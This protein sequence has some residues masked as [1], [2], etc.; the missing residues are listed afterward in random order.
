MLER[1]DRELLNK[2]TNGQSAH[3]A[4]VISSAI[5]YLGALSEKYENKKYENKKLYGLFLEGKYPEFFKEAYD[6]LLGMDVLPSPGSELEAS[7]EATEILEKFR[8]RR[9]D[10]REVDWDVYHHMR[11]YSAAK[12]ILALKDS[13]DEKALYDT[14]VKELLKIVCG[15]IKEG[16]RV[17]RLGL[18]VAFGI[19]EDFWRGRFQ[20]FVKRNFSNDDYLLSKEFTPDKIAVLV[21]LRFL[22]L[23]EKDPEK[24]KDF[25]VPFVQ[26]MIA[27][28]TF[29]ANYEKGYVPSKCATGTSNEFVMSLQ[30]VDPE[31]EIIIDENAYV[32]SKIRERLEQGLDEYLLRDGANEVALWDTWGELER[33]DIATEFA[34]MLTVVF[35]EEAC[36]AI[37]DDCEIHG[38]SLRDFL[39]H[40]NLATLEIPG[41]YQLDSFLVLASKRPAYRRVFEIIKTLQSSLISLDISDKNK[42]SYDRLDDI[43]SYFQEYDKRRD[44]SRLFDQEYIFLDLLGDELR[45]I[46][47]FLSGDNSTL[48]NISPEFRDFMKAVSFEH[49]NIFALLSELE[50]PEDT[51]VTRVIEQLSTEDARKIISENVKRI[52]SGLTIQAGEI[53]IVGEFELILPGEI[54]LNA[55]D[56]STLL[57]YAILVPKNEWYQP[58]N[59][60]GLS[61]DNLLKI[62]LEFFEKQDAGNELEREFKQ[63][64]PL[65]IVLYIKY[66]CD[67]TKISERISALASTPYFS[68]G[69]LWQR[70][71]LDPL[72]FREEP[73]DPDEALYKNKALDL[74]ILLYRNGDFIKLLKLD[75]EG[76]LFEEQVLPLIAKFNESMGDSTEEFCEVWGKM[77]EANVLDDITRKILWENP[78]S[79]REVYKVFS[80]LKNTDGIFDV[81]TWPEFLGA[82]VEDVDLNGLEGIAT[83]LRKVWIMFNVAME[84]KQE[85]I[86]NVTRIVAESQRSDDDEESLFDFILTFSRSVGIKD[87]EHLKYAFAVYSLLEYAGISST[88]NMQKVFVHADGMAD[89][90]ALLGELSD[91]DE[92]YL[93]QQT[94][95]LIIKY[96]SKLSVNI[97][98]YVN[99]QT[100]GEIDWPDVNSKAAAIFAIREYNEYLT[101][102]DA[103]IFL[104]PRGI[105]CLN[106]A[107]AYN[108]NFKFIKYF[109]TDLEYLLLGDDSHLLLSTEALTNFARYPREKEEDHVSCA[110]DLLCKYDEALYADVMNQEFIFMHPQY[111]KR[112][113]APRPLAYYLVDVLKALD[114]AKI[115]NEENR[116]A[117]MGL[118]PTKNMLFVLLTLKLLGDR[119]ILNQETFN[120]IMA[121]PDARREAVYRKLEELDSALD[122]I[123][124]H[125]T[126][127]DY[128]YPDDQFGRFFTDQAT[129][130]RPRQD[131]STIRQ[132]ACGCC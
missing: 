84:S 87:T 120:V 77:L 30:G 69:E 128:G 89:I 25:L 15:E 67:S 101:E 33:E 129:V 1:T 58:E 74:I 97:I 35:D 49:Y 40:E 79:A 28:S 8:L 98:Q 126:V 124:F 63:N 50:D 115:F 29:D 14:K 100:R 21:F 53:R 65:L 17:G 37:R 85:A 127:R 11:A 39:E 5:S 68:G 108:P 3:N 119:N 90:L 116:S 132:G 31:C 48:S 130:M 57:L 61:F 47:G 24:I 86:L 52:I 99:A 113:N 71:P 131:D 81:I 54:S 64:F 55:A 13:S 104:K 26:A 95:D 106:I 45:K 122:M 82:C 51:R 60:V 41:N 59:G 112:Y 118:E 114:G 70:L 2:V 23:G 4:K 125:K 94:F 22:E 34:N 121:L 27:S 91:P 73:I 83:T 32:L 88:E 76:D 10:S 44:K 43:L 62:I 117:I 6:V 102:C 110:I 20:D 96:L 123:N 36:K 38:I 92:S 42:Q 103:A 46:E 56:I 9:W 93:N 66:K 19:L 75:E 7:T 18:P 78:R 109:L 80:I 16:E 72:L 105:E 111:S 12:D 107:L